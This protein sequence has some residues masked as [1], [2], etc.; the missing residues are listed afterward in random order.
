[1]S[2]TAKLLALGLIVLAIAAGVWKIW[3]TA[4]Q[5]GYDRSQREYQAAAELQREANRGAAHK[6]DKKEAIR[7]VYRDRVITKTIT[8]VRDASAPLASC[9]L[10][11]DTIRLLNNAAKCAREGGSATCA[12][13]DALSGS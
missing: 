13:D 12:L 7:V 5:A 3:R 9:P 2:L 1:M 4:D 6:A 8:E 11:T 10:P